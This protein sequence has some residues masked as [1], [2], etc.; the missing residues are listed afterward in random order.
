[1]SEYLWYQKHRPERI[2]DY[3]FKDERMK[4]KVKEW[5]Q[6][7]DFPS[8][9]L[10]GIQGTGKSSLARVLATE[11]MIDLDTD[12]LTINFSNYGIDGVRNRVIPFI[13]KYPVMS[14]FRIVILEEFEKL[15]PASQQILN[16]IFDEYSTNTRFIGTTNNIN[17]VIPALQSRFQ[18]ITFDT[19]SKDDIIEMCLNIL[20]KESVEIE[21][22]E[23]F[24]E[25]VD[26][27]YPDIRKIINSMQLNTIDGVLYGISE[28][29]EGTDDIYEAWKDTWENGVDN[30]TIDYIIENDILDG[31]V[32][33]SNYEDY[34]EVM[35]KN[36]NKSSFGEEGYP[37]I[38]EEL[39]RS[40][41]TA[42]KDLS[43][44]SAL[45]RLKFTG[46]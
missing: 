12:V 16:N 21:S 1:M 26:K 10:A 44:K 13:S 38:A 46:E 11:C 4:S 33:E 40:Y 30:Q 24:F 3:V 41:F 23:S 15:Q 20:G 43:L 42:F 22:E 5:T 32:N 35:Y 18:T 31:N 45:I 2:D 19:H 9:L 25:H 27:F 6:E 39:Y 17:K 14:P 29:N 8:L 36:L 7:K 34:F 28:G 37:I